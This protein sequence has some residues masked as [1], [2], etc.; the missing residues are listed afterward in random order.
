[1]TAG[2]R[3]VGPNAGAEL[4]TIGLHGARVS[5]DFINL[6]SLRQAADG[7]AAD[8]AVLNQ[9]IDRRA[10]SRQ[11]VEQL[12]GERDRDQP[13]R[14]ARVPAEQRD[15]APAGE[16][17]QRAELEVAAKLE[18]DRV[19][20]LELAQRKAQEAAEL[21]Q[22]RAA[23]ALA[24]ERAAFERQ[25]AAALAA[26]QQ[27]AKDAQ[28][29]EDA[30]RRAIWLAEESQKAPAPIPMQVAPATVAPASPVDE[31][32]TLKLGDICARLGF[33]LQA[34]FIAD[35]LGIVHSATDKAAKLYHEAD[36]GRICDALIAHIRTVQHQQQAA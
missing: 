20:E 21:E 13:E 29:A 36:F 35:T 11:L 6:G 15:G 1:M 4:L 28:D 3:F 16:G 22:R 33:T 23:Q 26:E 17:Q 30:R 34:A 9:R 7:R 14:P 12:D 8:R 2:L 25:Q 27:R 31:P 10:A 5:A 19:A 18:R 24:D 32:A